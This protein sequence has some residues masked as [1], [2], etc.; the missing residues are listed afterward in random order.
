MIHL[1]A[2]S[3]LC[4]GLSVAPD[5]GALFAFLAVLVAKDARRLW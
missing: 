5:A 3:I 1:V 4:Y 2:L